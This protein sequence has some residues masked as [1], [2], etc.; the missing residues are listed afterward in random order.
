MAI[1]VCYD[2]SKAI[3]FT[4]HHTETKCRACLNWKWPGVSQAL[5]LLIFLEP[6]EIFV[7][8]QT[9]DQRKKDMKMINRL[10]ELGAK[11]HI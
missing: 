7:G 8:T 2:H 10:R 6:I 9:K 1:V 4:S 5:R 11:Q 3:E